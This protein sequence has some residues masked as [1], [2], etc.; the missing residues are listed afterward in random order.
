MTTRRAA[1]IWS[2][3]LRGSS[4]R[5]VL[6]FMSDHVDNP[7]RRG[8]RL[9]GRSRLR[10]GRSDRVGAPAANGSGRLMTLVGLTSFFGVLAA[11]NDATL[12]TI[13]LSLSRS[14]SRS[15]ST[16]CSPFPSGRLEGG[17]RGPRSSARWALVALGQPAILLV[18][19]GSDYCEDG[20]VDVPP[21]RLSRRTWPRRRD[22][23][24]DRPDRRDRRRG[25]GRDDPLAPLRQGIARPAPRSR[26]STSPRW[27]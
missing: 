12:F 23:G 27:S 14:S 25:D 17:P 20:A 7:A 16:S 4:R 22:R 18:T 5:G 2:F 8:A 11:A 6:V 3:A 15:S 13:G 10:H 26:R 9:R 24:R 21:N 19:P 1:A